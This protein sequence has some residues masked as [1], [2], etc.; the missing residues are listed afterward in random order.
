MPKDVQVEMPNGRLVCSA[1]EVERVLLRNTFE[2]TGGK[3]GERVYRK[4]LPDRKLVVTVPFHGGRD[5]PTGT[6]NKLI[7]AAEKS[8][9]QFR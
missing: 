4:I 5:I 9:D 3:G 6:L 1:R 8:R 7:K 2:H